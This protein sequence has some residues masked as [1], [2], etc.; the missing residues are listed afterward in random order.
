MK[1]TFDIECTPEEARRFLGLPDLTSVHQV[2]IDR[3]QKMATDTL[4]PDMM[5]EMMKGWGPMTEAGMSMWR[6]MMDQMS[7]KK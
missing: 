4:T 3:M 5:A 7:G 2:Y 6:A 1:V